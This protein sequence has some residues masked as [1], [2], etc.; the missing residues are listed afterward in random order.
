MRYL[1]SVGIWHRDLK[2]A[3]ILV[4]IDCTVKICDFGLA[5]AVVED[6][7]EDPLGLVTNTPSLHD[8]S[9]TNKVP[10]LTNKNSV[11]S[12][13]QKLGPRVLTG[14]VVTRWYRAPELILIHSRY[15]EAVDVWSLGC[16][17]YELLQMR[18]DY[19]PMANTRGPLFPGKNFDSK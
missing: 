18:K 11:S 8:D 3:N 19:C 9:N 13:V 17:L 7:S 1:H 15:T 2:P 16:I 4:N 10:A 14:H 6:A 12:A 5:R